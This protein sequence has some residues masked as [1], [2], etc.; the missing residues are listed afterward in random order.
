ME[1]GSRGLGVVSVEYKTSW[2]L[3]QTHLK[4]E[5]ENISIQCQIKQSLR[6]LPQRSRPL[7]NAYL[8]SPS[9]VGHPS[10]PVWARRAATDK[11][12]FQRSDSVGLVT[13]CVKKTFRL[14]VWLQYTELFPYE[15]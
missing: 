6:L 7:P 15:S 13:A 5:E 2:F 14:Y 12:S 3:P 8:L 4:T 1:K 11:S 10:P 9:G